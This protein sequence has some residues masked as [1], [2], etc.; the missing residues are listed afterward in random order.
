VKILR[1][2]LVKRIHVDQHRIKK[3]HKEGTSLPV[4]TVQVRGGPYKTQGI[5]I[6]GPSR[7]VYRPEKP[8]SCGAKV[9]IETLSAVRLYRPDARIKINI[10]QIKRT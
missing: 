8:L 7:L 4:L 10:C 6:D 9:W 3:N 5:Y 1:K 2:G